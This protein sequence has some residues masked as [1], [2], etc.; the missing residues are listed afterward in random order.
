MLFIYNPPL[1]VMLNLLLFPLSLRFTTRED[2]T[3]FCT[4]AI[5]CGQNTLF[6]LMV[7]S[8]PSAITLGVNCLLDNALLAFSFVVLHLQLVFKLPV[9]DNLDMLDTVF[10]FKFWVCIFLNLTVLELCIALESPVPR[11]AHTLILLLPPVS[12]FFWSQTRAPFSPLQHHV[13]MKSSFFFFY[14]NSGSYSYLY[15]A[16]LVPRK[17]E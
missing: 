1:G 7:P 12:P 9:C 2:N 5:F 17:R 13:R 14:S 3:V 11:V 15:K 10:F 6:M 4:S 16:R 8:Y